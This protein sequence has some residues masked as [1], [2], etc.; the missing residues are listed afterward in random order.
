[1]RFPRLAGAALVAVPAGAAAFVPPG[2]F[3]LSEAARAARARAGL[4]ATYTVVDATGR[5]ARAALT[6]A[7]GAKARFDP[8]PPP[9]GLDVLRALLAGDAKGAVDRCGADPDP[10]ALAL[11]DGH[12]AIIVGARDRRQSAPQVW[13]DQ[14]R[15]V[16]LR[17]LVADLDIRLLD[18]AGLLARAGLP[19]R[20]EVRRANR[21]VWQATLTAPP[22]TTR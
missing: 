17:A 21:T 13:V 1:M 18:T 16:P 12:I 8:H 7:K 11:H 10:T 9:P 6:L 2:P 15:F 14:R 19:A 5:S 4:T 20:I 22:H 3:V